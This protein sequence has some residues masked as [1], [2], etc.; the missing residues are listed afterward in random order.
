MTYDQQFNFAAV[1]KIYIEPTS[2]T[3]AATIQISD[4]QITNIDS[5]LADELGRKGFQMVKSKSAGGPV[6]ELVPGDR[7]PG[8]GQVK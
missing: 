5:A 3:D 2:R 7:G 6:P 8:Q 1:H 4:A